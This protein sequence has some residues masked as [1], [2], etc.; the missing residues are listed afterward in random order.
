MN[1][2]FL[3][4]YCILCSKAPLDIWF[5]DFGLALLFSWYFSAFLFFVICWIFFAYRLVFLISFN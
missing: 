1:S 2:Y 4:D 5:M 3:F